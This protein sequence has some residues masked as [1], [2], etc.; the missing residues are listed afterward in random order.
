MVALVV[1][2][3]Y[4]AFSL[5]RVVCTIISEIF[6][7]RVRGRAVSLATAVNWGAAFLVT[8]FFLTVVHEIGEA[9]TFFALALMCVFAYIFVWRFVPETRGCSLEEI[10][11]SGRA[12]SRPA[13]GRTP[14]PPSSR[15][16]D[17][18]ARLA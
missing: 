9:E 3:A 17:P 1:F 16:T 10:Q 2:I 6:P 11:E 12:T 18:I 8:Q 5:G 13:S 4:F 15:T 7:S 14:R